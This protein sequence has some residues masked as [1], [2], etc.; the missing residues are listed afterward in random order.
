MVLAIWEN[1]ILPELS[2]F[3]ANEI[4]YLSLLTIQNFKMAKWFKA[5]KY[6]TVENRDC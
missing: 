2:F 3:Y 6:V 1:T 4:K 5:L